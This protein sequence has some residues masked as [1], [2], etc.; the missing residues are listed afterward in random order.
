MYK[1]IYICTLIRYQHVLNFTLC[2]RNVYLLRD[3]TRHVNLLES[4]TCINNQPEYNSYF[5]VFDNFDIVVHH[6]KSYFACI[7][8]IPIGSFFRLRE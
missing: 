8:G 3:V 6:L 4:I 5:W 1:A 7:F 2:F